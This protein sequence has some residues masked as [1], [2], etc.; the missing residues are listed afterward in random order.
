MTTNRADFLTP[1]GRI[2]M[3]SLYE[4]QTKDADGNPLVYKKGPDA[5]K[6][7]S[8]YFFALAIP[9]AT[10]YAELGGQP[11][12]NWWQTPWGATIAKVGQACF[13][14]GQFQR[15]DFAWKIVDG[16]STIPNKKGVAPCSREGY[17]GHWVLSLSSTFAPKVYNRDGSAPIIEKDAV[18]AG[19]YVQVFGDVDGNES[20]NQPGIY[21]NH[22]MVALQG[23]GER[24]S[25]GPDA[26]SVGFGAGPAPAGMSAVPVGGMA[27]PPAAA[28]GPGPSFGGPAAFPA[29]PAAAGPGAFPGAPAAPAAAPVALPAPHTAIL[30]V[31]GAAG[32][33]MGMPAAPG[34]PAPAPAPAPAVPRMTAKA[35]GYT[36]EQWH[37]QGWTDSQL[38]EHGYMELP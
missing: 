27:A 11:A 13:P 31:P 32:A 29:T 7:R 35:G 22:R 26:S 5:G 16:D 3:G 28:P 37:A 17:P 1:T 23:Y 6:P 36:R 30:A 18:N 21:L 10:P 25:Y 24:I 33:P 12:A 34:A 19:D 2:V 14:Q 9:K 20:P 4:P 38:I 8:N 15:P